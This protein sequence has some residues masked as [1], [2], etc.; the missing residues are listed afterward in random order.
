MR[1]SDANTR[2][3]TYVNTLAMPDASND[4]RQTSLITRTNQGIK[5]INLSD[6]KYYSL[7]IT[8]LRVWLYKSS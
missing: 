6:N 4:L 3:K 1:S 7:I 2:E 8:N 5:T